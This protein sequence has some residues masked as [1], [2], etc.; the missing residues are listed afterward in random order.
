MVNLKHDST[1]FCKSY[2]LVAD[3]I[4][5][6]VYISKCV[7]SLHYTLS[8]YTALIK[9][10]D[11]GDDM[12]GSE[13]V[14]P[15]LNNVLVNHFVLKDNKMFT[16]EFFTHFIEPEYISVIFL[17][18]FYWNFKYSILKQFYY[19]LYGYRC[20]YSLP[21]VVSVVKRC[22]FLEI[23]SSLLLRTLHWIHL[24]CSFNSMASINLM[25]GMNLRW[26]TWYW[27]TIRL[28]NYSKEDI[29]I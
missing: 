6:I 22:I 27:Y 21:Q 24:R 11:D 29:V 7:Y 4:S 5:V 25:L 16:R 14:T 18:N 9:C 12:S 23:L 26:I 8:D 15:G 20:I 1:F 28:R 17:I 2:R 10:Q 13:T 3:R 19:L